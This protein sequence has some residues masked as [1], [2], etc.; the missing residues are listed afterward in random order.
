MPSKNTIKTY[1][2]GGYYHIYNRGVDKRE[3]FLDKQDCSVFL[4][5]LKFYLSPIEKALC[6]TPFKFRPKLQ[7]LNLSKEI[8]LLSFCIMPNHFH[9]QIK[10]HTKSGMERLTR[11]LLTAYV[12]YFNF[13]NKRKGVLFEGTYKAKLIEDDDQLLYLSSYIHRNPFKIKNPKFDFVEFSSYPYYLGFKKV[14]WVKPDEILSFF[15]SKKNAL[16]YK[17]FV[18]E[19]DPK[20]ILNEVI[21]EED[22]A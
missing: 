14:D 11:R 22:Y 16:S 6:N 19:H 9:L 5:Y 13:K 2:E 3:I 12:Q 21:I 15:K 7:Q 4:H 1:V 8:D 10:Q 18:E 17:N 20:N